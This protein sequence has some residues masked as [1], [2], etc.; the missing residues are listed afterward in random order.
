MLVA[1][2]SNWREGNWTNL[3]FKSVESSPESHWLDVT[4]AID[5]VMVTAWL[6]Q[7]LIKTSLQLLKYDYIKR[8]ITLNVITLSGFIIKVNEKKLKENFPHR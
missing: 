2:E 1:A 3:I 6:T 4:L 5:A 7:R 8:V